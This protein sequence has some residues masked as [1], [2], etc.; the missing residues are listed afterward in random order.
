MSPVS[1]NESG[2]SDCCLQPSW[3]SDYHASLTKQ[4]STQA[5]IRRDPSG[6]NAIALRSWYSLAVRPTDAVMSHTLGIQRFSQDQSI[7]NITCHHCK[8]T[9]VQQ[10]DNLFVHRPSPEINMSAFH[11]HGSACAV[12]HQGRAP[13]PVQFSNVWSINNLTPMNM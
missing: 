4:P 12:T 1:P 7:S 13:T 2:N 10:V 6:D 5:D 11:I 3:F 9:L 8:D